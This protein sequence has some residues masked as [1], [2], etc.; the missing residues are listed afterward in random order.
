[1]NKG[2]ISAPVA[3]H[4]PGI[5][6]GEGKYYIYGSHM[7]VAESTNLRDWTIIHDGVGPENKMFDNLF[8]EKEG[9]FDYVGTFNG[10]DMYAVWAPDVTYNEKLG[11]YMMYFC[12]SGT[13]VKSCLCMATA[14]SP[15]GPFHY[16]DTLLYSGFEPDTVNQTNLKEFLGEDAD[17]SKYLRKN[18]RYENLMWPNCIDPNLFHDADGRLWMVYGSWSGGIFLLEIDESTGYPIHPESDPKHNVDA[19]FGYKLIGGG[20]KSIEGPYILY[21]KESEYYY[22]FI[23]FGWLFR[24]GGYQI[25]LFRSKN[26]TGPYVDMNGKRLGRVHHHEPYGLKMMGNYNFPSLNM[27]YKAPGHNSAFE[28]VDGKLYV[29]H[30]QRFDMEYEIHEPRVHQLF[31]TSDNWLVASPFPT[32]GEMLC[33]KTYQPA[34]LAGTYYMVNHGSDIS[35]EIHDSIQIELTEAGEI[36]G[37]DTTGSFEP[38]PKGRI[39]LTI[40][41]VSYEGVI[42]QQNDEA[43]NQT[44]CISAAGANLT[45]WLVRYF[46]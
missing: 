13:Y 28:D 40:D 19:Y 7:A 2:N 22:L 41:G 34:E 25:R 10:G 21:D 14:D 42:I 8:D 29:V 36:K 39:A 6:R 3:V 32:E 4:D 43:G 27:A 45:A 17:L 11:K 12:V 9:V 1:M 44:L 37:S 15:E 18:G 20:H 23:S 38:E 35:S 24:D 16:V 33:E 30:H 26:P 31:R 5:F 46:D